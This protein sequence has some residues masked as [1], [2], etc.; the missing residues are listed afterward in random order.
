M[1]VQPPIGEDPYAPEGYNAVVVHEAMRMLK[2]PGHLYGGFYSDG[3]PDFHLER[4]GRY[5]E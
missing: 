4:V 1:Q 3:V 5:C 2:E